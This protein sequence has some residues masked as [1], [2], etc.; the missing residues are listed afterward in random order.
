M[1]RSASEASPRARSAR[2]AG[3]SACVSLT[4]LVALAAGGTVRTEP[5][6][7]GGTFQVA[8]PQVA[9][10]SIDPFIDN[11]PAMNFVFDATCASLLNSRDKSLPEGRVLVPEL[12]EALPEVSNG[13][14]T[15]RSPSI[16]AIASARERGRRRAGRMATFRRAKPDAEVTTGG[17]S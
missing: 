15:Y 13:G 9:V 14:R 7:E 3:F 8:L 2:A 1:R 6:R 10:T 12:A 5:G 17:R 16:S 11:L 4:L